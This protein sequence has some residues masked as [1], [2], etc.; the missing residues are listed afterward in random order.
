M[1]KLMLAACL[2]SMYSSAQA[3]PNIWMESFGQ[4]FNI[5]SIQDSRGQTLTVSCNSGAGE[6][7]DHSAYFETHNK[8]NY[9]N[10]DNKFP[11]SFIIDGVAVSP[12]TNTTTRNGAND[13]GQF[14]QAISKG[15]KIEV[16]IN[17][18]KMTTFTPAKSSMKIAK[19]INSST[20]QAQFYN[21]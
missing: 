7:Y 4:G 12:S 19:V 5:F 3:A 6:D 20:C 8:K 11:L 16:F 21:S 2:I 14:T 18:R 13:W 17:N 15:K 9:E 10:R 1:K